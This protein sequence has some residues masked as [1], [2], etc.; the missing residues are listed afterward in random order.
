M[1]PTVSLCIIARDEQE[2]LAACVRPVRQLVDEI[3]VVDTGS[4]DGSQD[5]ARRLGAK[6]FDFRW[7]DSFAAARNESLAHATGEYVL[8]LDADDRLDDENLCRLADLKS[9]MARERVDLFVARVFSPLAGGGGSWVSHTRLFRRAAG[10]RWTGRVH[11]E[12]VPEDGQPPL[13]M[14]WTDLVVR[15]VGYQ[16]CAGRMRKLQ[17]NMRLLQLDFATN[18]DDPSTLF[19][20]GWTYLEMG[21]LADAFRFFKRS[22]P[23]NPNPRK[24][25]TLMAETL[26]RQDR[27]AEAMEVCNDGLKRFPDDLEL[28]FLRASLLGVQGDLPAAEQTLVKL[29]NLPR[30]MYLQVGVEEGLQEERARFM[31]GLLFDE[32]G[33][34][35]EAETEF[36]AAI[37][38]N[39][40][41]TQAWV[42]LCQLY[43]SAR[44]WN[45][46]G[47]ALAELRQCPD[48]DLLAPVLEARSL[49][50]QGELAPARRLLEDVIV[51][52]PEAL[53]P[54]LVLSDLAARGGVDHQAA[55][56]IHRQV[57]QLDPSN[58][59][60]WE[61]LQVLLGSLGRSA[62]G[63][64]PA[65]APSDWG[66]TVERP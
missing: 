48:G 56:E 19:Y 44:H 16:D 28:L 5:V 37:R 29:V 4:T 22:L 39:P 45:G 8:W 65:V 27:L 51:R 24:L 42:G 58:S 49:I 2:N 25:Y 32:Q 55:I 47:H 26:R 6:V 17:R 30:Q 57:L 52:A 31:L 7:V 61:R 14:H 23:H 64:Q 38:H 20:L 9:R 1:G 66:A 3:I 34:W 13:V 50:A 41:S 62:P 10:L 43:V 53:W 36:R 35:A 60:A 15:H 59:I 33:R 12:L 46:L 11:E 40:R 63:T 18:P 21:R 54:K